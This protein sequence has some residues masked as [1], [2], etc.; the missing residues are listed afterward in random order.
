MS[1]SILEK[2]APEKLHY[3]HKAEGTLLEAASIQTSFSQCPPTPPLLKGDDNSKRQND[4][5]CWSSNVFRFP[6]IVV[7]NDEKK[8]D[9]KQHFP[10]L[11]LPN[12][13]QT[14]SCEIRS[15]TDPFLHASAVKPWGRMDFAREHGLSNATVSK[16][17]FKQLAPS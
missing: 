12:L 5:P 8:R 2:Y 17:F 15:F 1:L 11:S 9:V 3:F 13:F 16:T 7:T 6:N 4:I 10:V 14:P